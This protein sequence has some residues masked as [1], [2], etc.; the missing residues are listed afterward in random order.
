[1]TPIVVVVLLSSSGGALVSMPQGRKSDHS[2]IPCQALV[3]AKILIERSVMLPKCESCSIRVFDSFKAHH[4]R[5]DRPGNGE[6]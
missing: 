3:V 6:M 5:T 4:R 2:P 1:M